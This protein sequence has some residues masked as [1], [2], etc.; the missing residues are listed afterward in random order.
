VKHHFNLVKSKLFIL[1][2]IFLLLSCTQESHQLDWLEGKWY[3][4]EGTLVTVEEWEQ[5]GAHE[6]SGLGY[7]LDGLDSVFVEDMRIFKQN[8]SLYFEVMLPEEER[9]KYFVNISDDPEVLHFHNP[10][11]DFP[12]DLIYQVFRDSL[13]V[14]LKGGDR[15]ILLKFSH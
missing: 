10:Q 12:T 7:S 5:T 2:F 6:W 13:Q 4:E 8:D 15:N 14:H 1:S 3:M 11:N 9:P